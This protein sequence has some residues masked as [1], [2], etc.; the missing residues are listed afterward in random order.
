MALLEYNGDAEAAYSMRNAA[1]RMSGD[2]K[3]GRAMYAAGKCGVNSSSNTTNSRDYVRRAADTKKMKRVADA[4]NG[5]K[6][7]CDGVKSTI[8]NA[9]KYGKEKMKNLERTL[10][11]I[12]T[13]VIKD[14]KISASLF[15]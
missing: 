5:G 15:R 1:E 9:Y 7:V 6:D 14:L 13:E 8:K 4:V 10:A 2:H 12:R 3:I 11:N